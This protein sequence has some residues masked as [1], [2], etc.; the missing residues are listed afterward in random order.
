MQELYYWILDRSVV[1]RAIMG[2]PYVL[3]GFPSLHKMYTRWC[4]H[5]SPQPFERYALSGTHLIG[6]EIGVFRGDHAAK[7]LR[8]K[9]THLILVDAYEAK[10]LNTKV[11]K[12]V[13]KNWKIAVTR[14][15]G[16]FNVVFKFENSI[17]A[18]NSIGNNTLDFAYINASSAFDSVKSNIAAWWPKVQSG[19]IIGGHNFNFDC[20]EV[21]LAVSEFSIQNKL[22]LFVS[23]P[24]WWIKKPK[25]DSSQT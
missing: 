11:N 7:L 19:G 21:I 18:A 23:S 12:N 6:V 20:Q 13:L 14:F 4:Q 22:Q 25:L 16:R 9:V 2:I 10:S 17:V 1:F 8:K 24:D 15:N 5:Y 3:L